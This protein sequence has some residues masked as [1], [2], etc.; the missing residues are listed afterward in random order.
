MIF[1][2]SCLHRRIVT[3]WHYAVNKH[4]RL[5]RRGSVLLVSLDTS[6]Y[7]SAFSPLSLYV[8]FVFGDSVCG[9]IEQE[10]KTSMEYS[11]I[12]ALPILLL[13]GK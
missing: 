10:D 1:L 2:A 9:K 7:Q 3:S 11:S 13:L 4:S 6:P 5:I 12:L 8:A